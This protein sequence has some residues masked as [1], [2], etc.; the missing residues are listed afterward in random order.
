[1]GGHI[2][3]GV[4]DFGC[5]GPMFVAMIIFCSLLDIM[6]GTFEEKVRRSALPLVA[7]RLRSAR[8]SAPLLGSQIILGRC[9]MWKNV[10]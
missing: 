4:V 8:H 6:F 1:M 7:V 2:F 9:F 3:S 5:L 10:Q